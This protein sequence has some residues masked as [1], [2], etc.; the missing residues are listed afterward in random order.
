MIK[1]GLTEKQELM[2]YVKAL[3]EFYNICSNNNVVVSLG[4]FV[5]FLL[6][7]KNLIKNKLSNTLEEKNHLENGL[8]KLEEAEKYVGTLK[9]KSNKQKVEI[10]EKQN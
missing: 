7:F 9:E 6:I 2:S 10:E 3:V 4:K 8:N 5:Q 1:N